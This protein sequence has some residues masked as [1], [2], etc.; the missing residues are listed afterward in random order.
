MTLT[1]AQVIE[2]IQNQTGIP[3]N[4]SPEIVEPLLE[5]INNILASGED[6][7]ISGFGKFCAKEKI[8]RKGLNPYGFPAIRHLTAT[9]LYH[10]GYDVSIIQAILRHKNPTTT[11]RYLKSLGLEHTRKALEEGLK[12]PA[13]V[14]QNSKKIPSEAVL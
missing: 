8:E 14:I 4:K 2:S 9:I 12:K 7:M 13:T 5:I 1:K 3:I 11:N 10:K 6:V